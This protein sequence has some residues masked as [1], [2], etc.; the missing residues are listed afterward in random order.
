MLF[1]DGLFIDGLVISNQSES[2][3][4]ERLLPVEVVRNREGGIGLFFEFQFS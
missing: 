4:V 2:D 3:Q 1:T